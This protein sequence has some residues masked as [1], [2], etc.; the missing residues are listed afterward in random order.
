MRLETGAHL[1]H[2]TPGREEKHP[3]KQLIAILNI[4]SAAHVTHC[5]TSG[6]FLPI[7]NISI[8]N[9]YF[10][11]MT[12]CQAT[13]ECHKGCFVFNAN[14]QDSH[15]CD[16]LWLVSCAISLSPYSLT[17]YDELWWAQSASVNVNVRPGTWHWPAPASPGQLT[18][19]PGPLWPLC[20]ARAWPGNTALWLWVH[21]AGSK[22]FYSW[23]W[24]NKLYLP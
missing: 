20:R 12:R 9:I 3:E 7:L 18:V 17:C 2:R 10:I 21:L 4:G 5:Q 16:A 13:D 15:Y 1:S 19:H 11:L 24:L 8:F 22:S 23:L 14:F 6:N